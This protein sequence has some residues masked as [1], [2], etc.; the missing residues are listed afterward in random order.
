MV[1]RS[2]THRHGGLLGDMKD[3]L[4]GD[5]IKEFVSGGAKNYDYHTRGDK[6]ECKIRGFTRNVRGSQVLNYETMKQNI[7]AE[8][9]QPLD[10]K[11]TLQVTNPNHFDRNT[12]TKRIRLVKRVK[13]YGLVFDK[14]VVDV[15][16]RRSFPYGYQ[17]VDNE[18]N[19]LMEL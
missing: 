19:L 17:R 9:D 12:T 8:L 1:T 16:T 10:H 4:E 18:L 14:R 3:E 15:D 11:R 7:L 6:V 13:N 2:R 5:V